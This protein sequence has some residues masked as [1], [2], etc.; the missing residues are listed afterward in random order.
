MQHPP[1]RPYRSIRYRLSVDALHNP[2][3]H[4]HIFEKVWPFIVPTRANTESQ[5]LPPDIIY[6][7]LLNLGGPIRQRS[8]H[9]SGRIVRDHVTAAS[10]KLLGQRDRIRDEAIFDFIQTRESTSA[11]KI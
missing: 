5:K 1:G 10:Y 2:L 3:P 9:R 8:P 6:Q 4:A 11:A 7:K